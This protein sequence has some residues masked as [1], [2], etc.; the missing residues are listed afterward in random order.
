[1]YVAPDT[2]LIFIKNCPLASNLEHTILF[3][4]AGAQQAYFAG[5]SSQT[6][7]KYSFQR[8]TIG[9]VRVGIPWNDC[10]GFNYMAFQNHAHGDKWFY[11]FI[12]NYEY[13]NE[14]CTAVF[15]QIDVL[16]TYMFDWSIGSCYVERETTATD[17]PG[18]YLMDEGLATGEYVSDTPTSWRAIPHWL[19]ASTVDLLSSGFPNL[20]DPVKFYSRQC[21]EYNL[22]AG[23]STSGVVTALKP[24]I[25][26]GK[27]DAVKYLFPTVGQCLLV[28]AEPTDIKSVIGTQQAYDSPSTTRP[29]TFNGYEPK[30][31]KLLCYPYSFIAV[32]SSEGQV[33]QYRYE[34]FNNPEAIDFKIETSLTP[35]SYVKM[36]PANYF[37]K[38]LNREL[39]STL[40][41]LPLGGF[42][43]DVYS[44]WFALN[45]NSIRNT[46]FWENV[47]T[48]RTI[49]G[50]IAGGALSAG[51]TA[52][53][54]SAA[55]GAGF[56]ASQAFGM[57][58]PGYVGAALSV[59]G[60][61]INAGLSL[62]EKISTRNAAYR[63]M[64]AMPNESALQ[65]GTIDVQLSTGSYGW[66]IRQMHMLPEYL[67]SIDDYFSR[68]GYKIMQT[69]TP[70][71]NNRPVWDYIKTMDTDIGGN[72]PTLALTEIRSAFERG[73]T[74]WHNAATFGDYS[75]D[76]SV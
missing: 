70:T 12:T 67:K 21:C 76:N 53:R 20:T 13:I 19:I 41:P 30:N 37:G 73:I 6:V 59:A 63:D 35:Q 34:W 62:Q 3:E 4:S 57:A 72:V 61:A 54:E 36:S 11:A 65:S 31:K 5:L 60:T 22:F 50:G 24:L 56:T 10:I 48:V 15:F 7:D 52:A 18:E 74:F 23:A 69:K 9:I 46:E 26:A 38:E 33:A 44:T 55:V 42:N 71:L 45:K 32:V 58:L 43:Y 68:F 28:G 16:Q 51:Q 49:V 25:E 64:Q 27:T 75:Q 8:A 2:N 39:A 66:D 14:G 1:M 47:N 40:S 17:E 29:S